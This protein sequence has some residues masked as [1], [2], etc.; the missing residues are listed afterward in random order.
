MKE[1]F[2]K[3]LKLR[4]AYNSFAKNIGERSVYDFLDNKNPR[5]W[6]FGAFSWSC[7]QEGHN[8]W[9]EIDDEWDGL[10]YRTYEISKEERDFLQKNYVMFFID[11]N[12]HKDVSFD[13]GDVKKSTTVYRLY[14]REIGQ[15]KEKG[16]WVQSIKNVGGKAR[17]LEDA[18]VMD[19]ATVCGDAV[20]KDNAIIFDNAYVGGCACVGGNSRI[21]GSSAIK[22]NC[23]I[24]GTSD[25]SNSDVFGEATIYDSY[26][27][28]VVV[29]HN[30]LIR[31]GVINS[32]N[33]FCFFNNFGSSYCH[34]TA[35]KTN[36]DIVVNTDF[37]HGSLDEF[38]DYIRDK[39]LSTIDNRLNEYR[40]MARMI[41]ERLYYDDDRPA[42]NDDTL[43][44]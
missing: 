21:H 35:H 5:E 17:I 32:D 39:G 20:V 9:H 34:T 40:L 12:E 7:S 19:T 10:R 31:N 4:G 29:G 25:V 6:L 41:R 23:I 3:F 44:A 33:D 30:C 1:E 43:M 28:G 14:R 13:D 27:S 22:G 8:Y 2:I 36:V 11:E 18:V 37:F 26:V 38:D 15:E 16:G 42:N 24:T